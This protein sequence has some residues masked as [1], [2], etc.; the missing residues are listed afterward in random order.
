MCI[1]FLQVIL[2][3]QKFDFLKE[4]V[5]SI[6]DVQQSEDSQGTVHAVGRLCYHLERQMEQDFVGF[7]CH[8]VR[9]IV[10]AEMISNHADC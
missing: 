3:E 2:A 1:K 6:P 10:Q 5:A 7:L 8:Y 4:L 9:F